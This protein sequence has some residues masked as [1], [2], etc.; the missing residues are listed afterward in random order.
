MRKFALLIAAILSA[1]ARWTW[2]GLRW[3]LNPAPLQP[4]SASNVEHAIDELEQ[5]A[6]ETHNR[7]DGGGALSPGQTVWACVWA[8]GYEEAR[9][10]TSHLSETVAAWLAS[11]SQSD[12]IAIAHVD[13]HHVDAHIKG[14]SAIPGLSQVLS[15]E[16][17]RARQAE[18]REFIEFNNALIDEVFAEL[19]QDD[20]RYR[21]G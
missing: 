9:P 5:A 15:I 4:T 2:T 17:Y 1:P 10:E 13:P 18:E 19:T 8:D 20:T 6:V 12:R 21:F 3:I 7:G 16:E 11:L 14:R